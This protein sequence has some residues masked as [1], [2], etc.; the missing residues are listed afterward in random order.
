M[1]E[2][3]HNQVENE[4]LENETQEQGEHRDDENPEVENHESEEYF[5]GIEGEEPEKHEDPFRGEPAPEWVKELRVRDKANQKRIKELESQLSVQEKPQKIELG[6]KPTLE[7]VGYDTD[8]L[9]KRL[10]DW[11]IKKAQHD[12]QEKQAQAEQQK[13][14]QH[15]QDRVSN[16]ENKKTAIKSKVHDY[17][18]AE[19]FARD[20]LS[21]TQ[22]GILIQG[23]DNPEMLIYHL[24]KN[25]QKAKELAGITDPIQFAFKAAKL[26]A[27]LKVQQRKPQTS[28][29]RKPAGS[30]PLSGAV[31]AK[32]LELEKKAIQT[33]DRTELIKYRKLKGK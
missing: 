3:E 20:T 15:W 21:Q 16:Y 13:A 2:Q 8:E 5:V 9:E 10:N 26:D 27:Q 29:E 4:A 24:G 7:S 17:D 33:G 31:D 6:E 28:P 22:Q 23:A 18:E 25:P 1:S 30:A 19:E 32:E 11:Y 12:E 14:A